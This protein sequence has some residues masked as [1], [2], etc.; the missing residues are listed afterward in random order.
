MA[1]FKVVVSDPEAGT[2]YQRDVDGQDANRFLGR[3]L[4]EEVDGTAVGL[5]G[6]SL[7]LTGGSDTA[8]RPLRDDVAGPNLKQVLLTGG[9]GY[10]PQRDGERKR[11]TVRGREISEEVVQINAKIAA[12]GDESVEELLGEGGE[13]GEDED[14]DDE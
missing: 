5:S 1:D 3:D 14:A 11:V 13:D 2:T 4:G 7:E 6:Y 9:T 10:R 12:Y 8:G